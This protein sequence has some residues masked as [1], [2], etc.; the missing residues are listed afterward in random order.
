M[1]QHGGELFTH[2]LSLCM[3]NDSDIRQNYEGGGEEAMCGLLGLNCPRSIAWA[4][5]LCRVYQK[6]NNM[7]HW[8]PAS[9][10]LACSWNGLTRTHIARRAT[11]ISARSTISR[12]SPSHALT[13]TRAIS[14]KSLF[15]P[16]KS[17]KHEQQQ[18]ETS[19]VMLEPDNLF[20]MLSKSPIAELKDRAAI[21]NKY[22][23]CPVCDTHE[24]PEHKKQPVY[25]CP[26]C[27]YPTHCSEEHYHEG[28]EAHKEICHILREQNEDDHDL[29]SG[30]SMVEFEF[31]SKLNVNVL[32]MAW[33]AHCDCVKRCTRL[34]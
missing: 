16:S 10:T 4:L 29:R 27:G 25:E 31:P 21:I 1:I 14:L 2:T 13:A 8:R 5:L 17:K 11:A 9:R 28:H 34:R 24:T 12:S 33:H 20:H 30:R 15:T 26:D 23:V 6:V 7:H 22:G 18:Q 19:K 3:N 32:C